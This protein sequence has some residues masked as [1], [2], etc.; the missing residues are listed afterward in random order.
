MKK[1]LLLLL[2]FSQLAMAEPAPQDNVAQDARVKI[3]TIEPDRAVGYVIGELVPRTVKLEVAKPYTLLET[4][5]PIPGYE[6]RYKGQVSGI[7]LRKISTEVSSGTNSTTYTL[8]LAYQV[9]KTSLTATPAALPAETVKFSGNK[10][11]FDYRI[12]SWNFRISPLA[13]Y[14]SVVIEKDMSQYRGPLLLDASKHVQRMKILLGV[15]AVSLL[16]LLYILGKYTWLPR[17]GKPFAK[18]YRELH[19]LGKQPQTAQSL[20][21]ALQ[22]LHQAIN[23]SAGGSV[24]NAQAFIT[25]QPAFSHQQAD[26]EQ[27]F[28]L[29]RSVFFET[30][31]P[32]GIHQPEQWLRQLCL[33][34]RHTERGLK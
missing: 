29:S 32:A 8:H 5:L 11:I 33:N 10:Q 30:A 24:F 14:G 26:L 23:T 6:R 20:Q 18:A 12:P 1:I 16:G 4:S 7:E 27:F 34:C 13:V 25:S 3:E 2:S 17:M 22:S 21:Q 9:F 19:K 28:A 15:L 31:A